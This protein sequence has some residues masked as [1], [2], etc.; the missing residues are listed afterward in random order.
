MALAPADFYA[1]SRATGQPY[2]ES[3]EE[4]AEQAPQVLEFKRNQLKSQ[5][6]SNSNPIALGLGIGLGLAGLGG[7][8]FAARRMLRSGKATGQSGVSQTDL[9]KYD[10][11]QIREAGRT[12]P[13]FVEPS[14]V[15]M[16]A[17]SAP[18]QRTIDIETAVDDEVTRLLNDPGL[19]KF[20]E[21]EEAAEIIRQPEMR[22][23]QSRQQS[24][25]RRALS[26]TADD[27]LLGIRA[28]PTTSLVTQQQA[29][30]G[31]NVKQAIAALESGE[32]Q[33]TGRVKN[34]LQRNEDLNLG[35]IDMLEDNAPIN[36][37]ASQL[38]DGVPADQTED[39]L[40]FAQ[41]RMREI[42]AAQEEQGYRGLRA[43]QQMLQGAEGTRVKQAAELYAATG[44]PN[45]LSL[46]S[47]TPS[48]PIAV[49]PT[50]QQLVNMQSSKGNAPSE[51]S[52]SSL[53]SPFKKRELNVDTQ[54]DVDMRMTNR[55]SGLGA[56]L[57]TIPKTIINPAYAALEEQ[58]NMAMYGM[59]Q[60][61]PVAAN[62][63]NQNRQQFREGKA[64][65]REIINPE[66]LTLSQQLREAEAVR[67]EARNIIERQKSDIAQF[68]SVY[69]VADLQEG[70]RAFY[71]QTPE[72]QI[73]PETL[74]VR[75][76]RKAV[77]A[78]IVEKPAS[79]SSIR[80][81]G[82]AV[83]M[84]S[85]IPIE[86]ELASTAAAEMAMGPKIGMDP[87][88][89]EAMVSSPVRWD[90]SI[91][92]PAQRTP[93]GFVYTEQAMRRPSAPTGTET[94]R[95]AV[96]SPPAIARQSVNVSETIRRLQ[97]SNAPGAQQQLNQYLQSLRSRGI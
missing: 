41:N 19:L 13:T 59:Q 48:L 2:P 80:G 4:R 17:P 30:G 53:Y 40:G 72:G 89:R 10:T 86:R 20:V 8:G 91:H 27:I 21:A 77:P 96:K 58:T 6:S 14:K 84:E 1:Y 55:L 9:S 15:V 90:P 62:I 47:E 57:E 81:L 49:Q 43:E 44:D 75:S 63:Y 95:G 60:G 34:Q 51:L 3:P 79:G 46:I 26:A 94:F 67:G 52:T 93:E 22:A 71:Q 65:S 54:E 87:Q 5:E 24:Q 64:P 29:V 83:E 97:S 92:T 32:D 73:I 76:G 78:G 74:E 31:F 33:Q 38:P 12:K 85:Y 61:D 66:Y 50:S 28:E 18:V 69:K 23:E 35:Q 70:V 7:A 39:A 82:G 11:P 37:V 16:D 68:P 56:T 45:V 36:S 88:R 42:R 25:V